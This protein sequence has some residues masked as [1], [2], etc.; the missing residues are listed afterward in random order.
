MR[1]DYAKS[2]KYNKKLNTFDY[3]SCLRVMP[4]RRM[5]QVLPMLAVCIIFD[6]FNLKYRTKNKQTKNDSLDPRPVDTH[7]K[8][9]ET[10]LQALRR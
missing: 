8:F 4:M 1:F 3:A 7:L 10:K 9:P 5:F 2:C 6:T